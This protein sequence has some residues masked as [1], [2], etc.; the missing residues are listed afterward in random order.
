[1]SNVCLE[2]MLAG[3]RRHKEEESFRKKF[4][5]AL[6]IDYRD[7]SKRVEPTFRG[8]AKKISTLNKQTLDLLQKKTSRV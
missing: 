1:M 3:G 4:G 5:F 6:D 8:N 2:K 7:D